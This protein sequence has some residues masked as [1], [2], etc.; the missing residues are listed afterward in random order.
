[1]ALRMYDLIKKKRDGG[2]LT[3]EEI[4]AFVAGYTAGEI[5]DY[6]A[7]ALLMAIY[8]RGMDLRETTDLTLA[9]RDSGTIL[10]L[11]HICSLRVDKHSTGG[12]GDKTSI[13]VAPIVASLGLKVAKM[14]GRGLGHTGG[15]VDKLEAIAGFRTDLSTEEF[16][17]AVAE[18][19]IAIIGQTAT[20]APADKKLYALRDVT[21]TVDSMPLIA[22]SIM[23]KKLAAND[24]CIV[25]DVKTGSGSF[26]KTL[27]DSRTLARLMVDIG[28][29]AGKK[30]C[31]LITDMDAPLG[32]A[33]GNSLEVIEAIDTLR[34]EGPEDF[35]AL[36]VALATEMLAL[37]GMGDR[38]T[39]REMVNEAISSGRALRKLAEMV[40]VQGG[41]PAFV[42]DTSRFPRAPYQREIYAPDG[43][44]ITHMN[45]EELG[46][47]SLTLGA[48]RNTIDGVIDMSAGF[49]L[50]KKTGETVTKGE[51]IATLY[52]S[53]EASLDEAERRFL[54]SVQIGI[55]P[56]APRP[57]IFERVE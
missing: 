46:E 10:D 22:A 28:K 12:V 53:A 45:T 49:V 42:A 9:V 40:R 8:F 50:D 44:Y 37:A 14:S 55:D 13:A 17:R 38:D 27:E 35:R 23:G 26:M 36:T 31:A 54:R 57:L 43:G 47:V 32:R 4:R 6:Q 7:S 30:M 20:L 52:T 34:G 29:R 1:M 18:T 56:P 3:T 15:T 24:D 11:S 33:V 5:P 19:G 51:R 21:A 16:E 39:C 41:D 25:L 2:T 48:G